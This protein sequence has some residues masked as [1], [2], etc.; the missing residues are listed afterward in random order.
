MAARTGTIFDDELLAE[1]LGEPLAYQTSV[2]VP[3]TASRTADDDADRTR[4]IGLRPCD[5][6]HDRQRGSAHGQTEKFPAGK[7]HWR[8]PP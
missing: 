2:E 1:P 6:R 3:R 5:P 7:F 4:R 8:P